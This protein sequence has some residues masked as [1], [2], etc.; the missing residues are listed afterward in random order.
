MA[1]KVVNDY[2]VPAGVGVLDIGLKKWDESRLKVNPKAMEFAPIAP[3]AIVG[4]GTLARVANFMSRYDEPIKM[5]VAASM[6]GVVNKIY[7]WIV[8][9]VAPTASYAGNRTR[10][11]V[12]DI[13]M[14]RSGVSS[15]KPGFEKTSI[16]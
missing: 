3:L 5:A 13:S 2:I 4:A 7:D 6:P 11:R 15:S 14:A 9:P 12:R 8:K 1:I 16:I 10:E